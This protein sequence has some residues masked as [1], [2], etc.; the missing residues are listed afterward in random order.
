M[1][2]NVAFAIYIYGEQSIVLVLVPH[3]DSDKY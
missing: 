3:V 2:F 1:K